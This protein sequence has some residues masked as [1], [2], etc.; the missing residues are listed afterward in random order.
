MSWMSPLAHLDPALHAHWISLNLAPGPWV[1]ASHWPQLLPP[2]LQAMLGEGMP[3]PVQRAAWCEANACAIR[4]F[5]LSPVEDLSDPCLAA[6]LLPQPGWSR[7]LLHCGLRVLGPQVRRVIAGHEVQA[8]LAQWGDEGLA[9][10]RRHG[11]G[12]SASSPQQEGR[13]SQEAALLMPEEA[14]G[15]ALQ[16]GQAMAAVASGQAS[17][18]VA[19]RLRLRLPPDA[20]VGAVYLPAPWT[21]TEGAWQAAFEVLQEIDPSWCSSFPVRH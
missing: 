10:A 11:G 18:P 20:G 5:G 14:E 8:L 12:S 4:H 15:Q 13:P 6:A 21:E 17:E 3:A 2:E 19:Q 1:H 7:W 16:L 9:F